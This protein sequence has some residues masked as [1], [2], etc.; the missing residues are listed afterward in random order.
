[1]KKVTY[2]I[3]DIEYFRRDFK[4]NCGIAED[5]AE[6]MIEDKEPFRC[7]YTLTGSGKTVQKYTLTDFNGKN[8]DINKLNGFQRGICLNDCYAHFIGGKYHD[9]SDK[10]LRSNRHKRRNH[11][12]KICAKGLIMKTTLLCRAS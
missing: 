12:G 11:S 5:K 7:I 3:D 2:Y 4:E 6:E 10:P 1:M 9:D 8:I